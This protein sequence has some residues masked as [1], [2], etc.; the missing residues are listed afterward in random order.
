MKFQGVVASETRLVAAGDYDTILISDST[1]LPVDPEVE[2]PV[3]VTEFQSW[4][5]IKFTASD[6]LVPTISGPNAD[7]DHDKLPNL[8]EYA[9][10]LEPQAAGTAGLPVIDTDT[11]HW[12]FTYTRPNN[13]PDITYTVEVSTDLTVWTDAGVTVERITL[14]EL[15]TWQAKYSLVEPNAFFRLKVTQ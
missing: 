15:E 3:A 14:G 6:L 9:L 1:V 13:R 8:V 2:S 7:P 4:L 12:L 11:T 5:A 10:G